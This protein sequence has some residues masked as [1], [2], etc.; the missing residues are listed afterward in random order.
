MNIICLS[1]SHKKAKISDLEG[2]RI[3]DKESFYKSISKIDE[4]IECVLIQT[5]TS[6]LS[7]A[8]KHDEFTLESFKSKVLLF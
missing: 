2:I 4:I 1:F 8:K 3:K 5:C 6:D 7:E